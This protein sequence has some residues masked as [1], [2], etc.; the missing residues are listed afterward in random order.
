MTSVQYLAKLL[1]S[2]FPDD[3]RVTWF[4]S[5]DGEGFYYILLA[6]S[7]YAVM[8]P[9]SKRKAT[10]LVCLTLAHEVGHIKM[11][12][13]IRRDEGLLLNLFDGIPWWFRKVQRVWYWNRPL[14]WIRRMSGF[15][16]KLKYAPYDRLVGRYRWEHELFA[17]W[18][19]FKGGRV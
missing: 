10:P 16:H 4:D 3:V 19:A 14:R 8:I 2:G 11:M 17:D 6:D 7:A 13:L 9:K 18:Y 1:T 5:N 15:G 12:C